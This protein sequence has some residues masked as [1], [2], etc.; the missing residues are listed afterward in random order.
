M[1]W[2]IIQSFIRHSLT[3][4]G[5]L[6]VTKGMAS[7]SDTDTAVGAIM[8]LIG[9][10]HSIFVKWAA[11][12]ASPASSSAAGTSVPVKILF[13]CALAGSGFCLAGCQST[14]QQITYQAAGT[15]VITVGAA[16]TAW[17]TFVAA[18]HPGTNEELAVETA[19][20]QYQA[21]MAVV[22]D[23]GEA[24][25]ATGGTNATAVAALS[26]AIAN[27]SQELSDLESLITSFGVQL[28]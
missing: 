19:Y 11:S 24:Y 7:Q 2:Q 21:S 16:M 17:G 27:S 8:V 9:I 28:Q 25:A 5:A 18:E 26:Q 23:A 13:L 12:K 4:G 3:S 22:C 20:D 15:T 14:P 6:L 1:L 10:G